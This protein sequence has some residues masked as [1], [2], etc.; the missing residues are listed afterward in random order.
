ME[1]K[2]FVFPMLLFLSS[3]ALAS[4]DQK[5][6]DELKRQQLIEDSLK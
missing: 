3:V 4:D 5:L 1:K 6:E 2:S